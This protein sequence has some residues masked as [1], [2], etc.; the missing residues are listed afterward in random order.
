VAETPAE[1]VCR[2]A[3]A[4]EEARTVLATKERELEEARVILWTTQALTAP[5][6]RPESEYVKAK[7]VAERL[8]VSESQVYE[9][10]LRGDLVSIQ[11]G[12]SRRIQNASV[13]RYIKLHGGR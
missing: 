11:V 12:R 3:L 6:P 10:A 13:A 8:G 7:D 9:M 1:A 2:C 4:V 5:S